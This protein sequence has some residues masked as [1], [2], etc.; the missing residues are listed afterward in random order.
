MN[1]GPRINGTL[2]WYYSICKRE[3]WLMSRHLTPDEDYESMVLGKVIHEQHYTRGKKELEISNSKI[4]LM[5]QVDGSILVSEIKKS[6]KFI[7]SALLQLKYY[8]LLFKERG[9]MAKGALRVPE[10]KK[11]ILVNLTPDDVDN[12]EAVKKEINAIVSSDGPPRA[13]KIGYCKSCA[14]SEF[15]WS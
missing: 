6:S 9:V 5:Q 3:V 11:E 14:Y 13:L 1:E 12:L 7:E 4:D 2:V 10:E 8:L 15:C